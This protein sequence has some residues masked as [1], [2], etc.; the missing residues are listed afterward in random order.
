MMPSPPSGPLRVIS[1]QMKRPTTTGGMPIPVCTMDRSSVRP[2]NRPLASASPMGQPTRSERPVAAREMMSERAAIPYTSASPA[3]RRLNASPSPPPR[4]PTGGRM[5][6]WAA[7]PCRTEPANQLLRGRRGEIFDECAAGLDGHVRMP[8]RIDRVDPIFVDQSPVPFEDDL[9]REPRRKREQRGA[10]GQ[11]VGTTLACHEKRG[12]LAL[13]GF[14]AAGN[15]VGV[16]PRLG[17]E[18]ELAH[19]SAGPIPAGDEWT[20]P[21]NR[22]ERVIEVR[23][24]ACAGRIVRR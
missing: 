5:E 15:R 24:G 18:R 10:V 22:I 8:F 21:G 11:G 4:S 6:E 7:E 17:P 16:D 2:G 3:A 23:G 19:L 1:S 20:V 13:A 9:E 12:A 14:P